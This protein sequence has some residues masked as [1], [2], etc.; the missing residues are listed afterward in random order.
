M[1]KLQ[2]NAKEI[3]YTIDRFSGINESTG[4]NATKK[5]GEASYM[6]NYR[7]TEGG[8]LTVRHGVVED[9][10]P[11][12][13]M[14]GHVT[15]MWCGYLEGK[16]TLAYIQGRTLYLKDSGGTYYTQ[17]ED[18]YDSA[19]AYVFFFGGALYYLNGKDIYKLSDLAALNRVEGYIPT[20]V[21]AA[22]P[23]G[24]GTLYEQVN[25]LTSKRKVRYSADG[26]STKYYLPEKHW[27][28]VLSV[29]VAGETQEID[30]DYTVPDVTGYAEYIE[31]TKAP[32]AGVNNI[33]VE[34][35][36]RKRRGVLCSV[37]P[38]QTQIDISASLQ[39]KESFGDVLIVSKENSTG[40][41]DAFD[42]NEDYTVSGTIVTLT[43]APTAATKYGVTYTYSDYFRHEVCGM[44][45]SETYNGAQDTRVFLYGDG[46]NIALY[47]GLDESGHGTAEYFPDLNEIEIG[48]ANTPI[49]AMIRH[50]NRLLAFK[51]NEAYSIYYCAT[52]LEDG[53]TIAGFYLN[54]INRD[55]GSY[56]MRAVS[57]ENRIRT[58][59]NQSI[60]EWRSTNSSGNI[61]SDARNVE[62]ISQR[63]QK[64]FK[65]FSVYESIQL[66]NNFTHEYYCFN[67]GT[68]I[69]NN[70]LNDTWYVY[71]GFLEDGD[72]VEDAV[73][74][75]GK[76]WIGTANGRLMYFDEDALTDNAGTLI[77]A[78][79]HSHWLDFGKPQYL[80]YSPKLW[81]TGIS[82]VLNGDGN[83]QV[84]VITDNS[85]ST[86]WQSVYFQRAESVPET[87][88]SLLKKQ[89]FLYY[90]LKLKTEEAEAH[91]TI[92]GTVIRT[93]YTIPQ[94]H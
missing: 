72:E 79:W 27:A 91:A 55:I 39:N 87:N 30:T 41:Y 15:G 73:I 81:V 51:P 24:N 14:S 34:Y 74:Y 5:H 29:T 84:G 77:Q 10:K 28:K 32:K 67:K 12:Q 16:E 52:S 60:Y 26:A 7:V 22:A 9:P 42:A 43:E 6:R 53:N 86:A 82:A 36:L 21:I 64:T 93:N 89:K 37:A 66:Y 69:V 25:K 44:L 83:V 45:R 76:V 13:N 40:G 19:N 56:N 23:D 48:D 78:E 3:V 33:E 88:R 65:D 38:G 8:A 62:V 4:S 85:N 35:D 50:R 68:A 58:I 94:R 2:S 1:S 31:F 63:V 70:T 18:D 92:T 11:F 59:S 49:V 54:T 71:D 20:V 17:S 47:S 90:K 80:K 46:S 75:G 61:T 57:V